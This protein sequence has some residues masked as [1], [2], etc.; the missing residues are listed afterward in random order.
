MKGDRLSASSVTAAPQ[1]S[2]PTDGK[3]NFKYPVLQP[4]I[5]LLQ[6]QVFLERIQGEITQMAQALQA[7]GIPISLVMNSV[8]ETGKELIKLLDSKSSLEEGGEI[9]MR[10]FDRYVLLFVFVLLLS[11]LTQAYNSVHVC[12]A[13]DASHP[14]F[15][16]NADSFIHSSTL[17][18]PHG[19]S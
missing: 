7:A 9:I 15:A 6:Y 14:S 19:R 12:V 5:D 1:I 13:V 18:T 17:P 8:G 10:I 4:I 2:T 11:T 3:S 16:I